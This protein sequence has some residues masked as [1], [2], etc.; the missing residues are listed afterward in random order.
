M[1][2]IYIQI[3]DLVAN[4]FIDLIET[5]SRREI[6]YSDLDDYGARVIEQLNSSGELKAVL[7]VSRESQAA[8]IEDYSDMFE[9]FEKDGSKGI[10]LLAHVSPLDLWERFCTSLSYTVLK[11]FQAPAVKRALGVL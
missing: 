2:N 10:R 1:H 6:F 3:E 11:A 5:D 8:V 4:A 7:V 9:A